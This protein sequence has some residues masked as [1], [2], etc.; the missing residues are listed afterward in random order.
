MATVTKP[1]TF[2]SGTTIVASE[3]NDDFDTIY[4]EFNG[5]VDNANLKAAA[6][7][8]Y[9]KLA[10]T[11]AILAADLT[12]G[13]AP[14][15]GAA[16]T[17]DMGTGA[18]DAKVV[19]VAN[20]NVTAAGTGANTTET[21]LISYS[22]PA[23]SLSANGKAVRIYAW[24]TTTAAAANRLVKLYFGAGTVVTGTVS[25][26]AV[27]VW[28]I[29]ATVVRTGATTQLLSGYFADNAAST[30][31][32]LSGTPT[33]TLTGA[34]T[35]KVTGTNGTAVANQVRQLGMIVEFLN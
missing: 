24:G 10:L 35:I 14:A 29:A 6:A 5:N 31:L 9:S 23:N 15:L 1:T 4:N 21:D 18:G 34:V 3:V 30:F 22:L 27:T 28:Q 8:A 17:V 25:I 13:I 19:G 2:T 20:V 26:N 7:I 11:G 33:E 32:P 16:T 12:S